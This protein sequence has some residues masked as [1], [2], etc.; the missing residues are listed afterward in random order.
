M[1]TPFGYPGP[2]MSPFFVPCQA[3]FWLLASCPIC[4]FPHTG[5]DLFVKKSS[6]FFSAATHPVAETSFHFSLFVS[7]IPDPRPRIFPPSFGAPSSPPFPVFA[8]SLFNALQCFDTPSHEPRR[9][10]EF[11]QYSCPHSP[12]T[13]APPS[14]WILMTLGELE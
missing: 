12:Q 2:E 3:V 9:S 14:L 10:F 8:A 5:C 11:S 13:P 4:R 6:T 7:T 1:T